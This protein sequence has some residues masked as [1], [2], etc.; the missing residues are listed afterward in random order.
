MRLGRIMGAAA[1]AASSLRMRRRSV[2]G[3]GFI[4]N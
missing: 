2:V 4:W 3:L 1:D